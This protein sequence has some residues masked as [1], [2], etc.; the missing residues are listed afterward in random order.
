MS[1]L[2]EMRTDVRERIGEDVADFFTDAEVDRALNLAQTTFT[3]EELWPWLFTE[4]E[5][6]IAEAVDELELPSNVSIHRAFNLSVMGGSLIRGRM[7]ERLAPAAGFRARFEY[8]TLPQ[9]PAYYYLTAS[10]R[11]V[12][13]I[14]YVVK[15]V[16]T[17]D[18]DYDVSAL[19]LRVPVDLVANDDFPDLPDE[20][21]PAL[22]AWAAGHLFLKETG[23]VS[24]KAA[25]QFGLYGEVLRQARKVLEVHPDENVAWG[26]E[27]PTRLRRRTSLRDRIPLTLGP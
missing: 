12:A 21:H 2:T 16:P 17:P 9:T 26:R 4:W 15:F 13:E 27:T 6:T 22:P 10:T 1:T 24:Q 14:L 3:A 20:F 11:D 25:E 5:T 19:Y 8:E 18:T 23:S 7:L